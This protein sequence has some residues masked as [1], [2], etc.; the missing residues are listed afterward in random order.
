[1]VGAFMAFMTYAILFAQEAANNSGGIDP[2]WIILP[3]ALTFILGAVTWQTNRSAK[4][5]EQKQRDLELAIHKDENDIEKVKTV[6]DAYEEQMHALT[7]IN[8]ELSADLLG[9]QK[10]VLALRAEMGKLE[11]KLHS[12]EVEILSCH[13]ERDALRDRVVELESALD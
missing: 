2:I 9:T 8:K 6:L 11:V 12:M 4:I 10:E 13:A 1:M 3:S 5:R 7:G